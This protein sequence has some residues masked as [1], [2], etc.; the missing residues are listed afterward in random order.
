MVMFDMFEFWS[1]AKKRRARRLYEQQKE[2]EMPTFYLQVKAENADKFLDT[3]R[4]LIA[5]SHLNIEYADGAYRASLT[6]DY[7][8]ENYRFGCIIENDFLLDCSLIYKAMKEITYAD[9]SEQEPC[10]RELLQIGVLHRCRYIKRYAWYKS[11][12]PWATRKIR[13]H[14]PQYYCISNDILLIGLSSFA[15]VRSQFDG[16]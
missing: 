15:E 16:Y 10:F 2:R 14:K 1:T 7:N 13:G 3:A 5:K 8:R 11:H 6:V 4:D 12:V 9:M